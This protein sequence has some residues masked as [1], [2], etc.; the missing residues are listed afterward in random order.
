MI[1][2]FTLTFSFERE[3]LEQSK[4]KIDTVLTFTHLT[5]DN[6]SLLDH[7]EYFRVNK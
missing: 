2:I 3:L 5:L 6:T 4:T 7:I 1:F